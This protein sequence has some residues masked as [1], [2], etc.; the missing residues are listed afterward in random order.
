MVDRFGC[1]AATAV[2]TFDFVTNVSVV[3]LFR[4]LRRRTV[5][6]PANLRG[7]FVFFLRRP[8]VTQIANLDVQ[9]AKALIDIKILDIQIRLSRFC[10]H[11]AFSYPT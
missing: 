3:I 10:V 11:S 6:R 4:Q 1:F 7:K 2:D 9:L 5:G 8:R